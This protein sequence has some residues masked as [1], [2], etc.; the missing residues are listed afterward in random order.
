MSDLVSVLG[1]FDESAEAFIHD[2]V[3]WRLINQQFSLELL[4]GSSVFRIG[5]AIQCQLV[6]N[7]A[8]GC[9]QTRPQNMV[10]SARAIER[11]IYKPFERLR[12]FSFELVKDLHSDV[13]KRLSAAAFSP[14]PDSELRTLIITRSEFSHFSFEHCF[15]DLFQLHSRKF[16]QCTCPAA[17]RPTGFFPVLVVGQYFGG[18]FRQKIE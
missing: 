6:K 18:S 13:T 1:E 2:A 16:A 5:P 12:L 4:Q 7:K 17:Y 11:S 15:P 10:I 14:H 8:F 3:H 9:G